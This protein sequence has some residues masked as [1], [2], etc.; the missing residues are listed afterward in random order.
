MSP[1]AASLR[2]AIGAALLAGTFATHAADVTVQPATGNGFVVRDAAGANERLRVQESGAITLPSLPGAIAQSTGV[3]MNGAGL[4]GPCSGGSGS[5]PAYTAATG[6]S[7]NGTTFSVAP[8]YQLP[9]GCAANQIAQWNGTGWA[10]ANS[11]TLPAGTAN[12]TLRY[13]ASTAPIANNML[14]AFADGGLLATGTSGIG[15]VPDT[16]AGARMM[17]YPGKRAFRAGYVGGA[18]WD[19]ANVGASSIALGHDTKASGDNSTALGAS[20]TASGNGSTAMG[21]AT[22]ASGGEAVAM[23]DTTTASGTDSTAMG[24]ATKASGDFSTA[25]GNATTADGK[26]S[27][28]I[29]FQT[30]AGG[31]NSIAI[32][33][34]SNATG[35]YSVALGDHVNAMGVNSFIFGDGTSTPNQ[36]FA[37]AARSFIVYASG[38]IG[39]NGQVTVNN[40]GETINNGALTVNGTTSVTADYEYYPNIINPGYCSGCTAPVSV[41]APNG[42]VMAQEFDALSD[43]R[44]K[45]IAGHSD[46]ARDLATL[47]AIE[48]TDYTMKD[49]IVHGNAPFKKVIAQQVER[50]YPQ[51]VSKHTD[52]IPNV[53]KVARK[54]EQV[55]GGYKLGFDTPHGLAKTAKKLR[56][57]PEGTTTFEQ[58]D[59]V[60]IPSDREV[61]VKASGWTA[62]RVFVFGEQVDDL[63]SVDY[64]GLTAL[65]VSATQELSK[66]LDAQQTQQSQLTAQLADKDK[67]IAALQDR[68]AA[69]D[70]KLAALQA[71]GGEIA[72]LKAAVT[73]LQRG[74]MESLLTTASAQP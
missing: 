28:A 37:T 43:A 58:V 48:I 1:K 72:V 68:L 55:E 4:L 15:T 62:E 36:N 19:D 50:V 27:T 44:I 53:Y 73:A 14:L 59:V 40:G 17:W 39:L 66:R 10:C 65:N 26:N 24:F 46:A 16:G 69:Q 6:L 63:R 35:D 21:A 56:L 32:G 29:G 52:F 8:T 60:A 12:Q 22:T 11:A 31:T 49:K 33:S 51:I 23:G 57:L 20:T 61:V 74:Q 54:V 67:Q 47:N 45:N 13:D 30:V 25:L 42:R 64:E 3:C 41:Y 70:A 2:C 5:G 34:N 38:G 7:L 71:Q 18:Q 9:Q